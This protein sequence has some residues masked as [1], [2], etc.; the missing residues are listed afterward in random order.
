MDISEDQGIL[1]DLH[2][3]SLS[4]DSTMIES[5]GS[6]YG[7][8]VCNCKERGIY[9]CN[10][11]RRYSDL[12]ARWGWD[13]YRERYIYGRSLYELIASDSY[14]GLPIF[15][16]MAQAQRHDSVLSIATLHEARR[17]Y[18]D[19]S[20]REFSGD[21]AHDAYPIYQL[22][23]HWDIGAI[24]ALNSK[25]EGHF[26]YDPALRLTEDGVPVCQGGY[27]MVY[28]GYLAR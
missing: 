27:E 4:G 5:G 21:S 9:R 18:E 1:N 8:K 13:S 28:Q 10:C 19:C 17:L 7:V 3:L 15:L 6:P 25:N 24:I 22:L 11:P 20:F 16:K 2:G 23:N 14:S 12:G 26:T